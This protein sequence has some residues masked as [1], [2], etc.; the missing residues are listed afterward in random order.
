VR[1]FYAPYRGRYPEK[2]S[3]IRPRER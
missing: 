3:Q 1:A 2:E